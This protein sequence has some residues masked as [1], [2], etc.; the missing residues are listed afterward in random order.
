MGP[1]IPPSLRQNG[2]LQKCDLLYFRCD[3]HQ[4][5]RNCPASHEQLCADSKAKTDQQQG[6]RLGWTLRRVRQPVVRQ[7]RN[8]HLL[9]V[10]CHAG[11]PTHLHP[12]LV[13]F[14]VLRE[15]QRQ[16][17]LNKH[18]KDKQDNSSGV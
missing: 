17:I 6:Q 11:L 15:M 10:S 9:R 16:E 1:E 14:H 2:P 7:G 8:S 3:V 5:L 18:V 13:H 4:H 12:F